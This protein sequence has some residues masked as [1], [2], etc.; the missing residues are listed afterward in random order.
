MAKYILVSLPST[1]DSLRATIADNGNVVPFTIPKFKIG[2]LDALVQQADDLA[3][4]DSAC[5]TL[6]AKVGDS[7]R[8]LY[9][10]DDQKAGE[11]KVVN[12]STETIASPLLLAVHLLILA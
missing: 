12:D 11:Q 7:L 1:L 8:T 6:V 10:G 5:Q 3:K 4:L 9:D 2:A